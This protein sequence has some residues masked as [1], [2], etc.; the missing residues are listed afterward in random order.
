MYYF[1]VYAVLYIDYFSW[2]LS[3]GGRMRLLI[4]N[5]GIEFQKNS[6]SKVILLEIAQFTQL[7]ISQSSLSVCCIFTPFLCICTVNTWIKSVWGR[8]GKGRKEPY[9]LSFHPYRRV[10]SVSLP[11]SNFPEGK[12]EK[13]GI[14]LIRL[15]IQKELNFNA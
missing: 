3:A 9:G 5:N 1:V 7:L 13:E 2:E 12:T 4:I 15:E 8:N 14:L 10:V 6:W 11:S